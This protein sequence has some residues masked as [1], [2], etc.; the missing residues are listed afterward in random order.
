[1][2]VGWNTVGGAGPGSATGDFGL[3]VGAGVSMLPLAV[4]AVK[5]SQPIIGVH[6]EYSENRRVRLGCG[7]S[8][9]LYTEAGS[10]MNLCEPHCLSD[11]GGHGMCAKLKL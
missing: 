6:V 4:D 3:S 7:A 9:G 10:Y 5:G 1:M 2:A 11:S 8:K